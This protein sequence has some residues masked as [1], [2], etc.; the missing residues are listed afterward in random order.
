MAEDEHHHNPAEECRHGVVAPVGARDRIVHVGV[1][2]IKVRV[3]IML[4]KLKMDGHPGQPR[5]HGAC[6]EL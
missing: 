3:R 5:H 6:T 4:V 1:S 2:E